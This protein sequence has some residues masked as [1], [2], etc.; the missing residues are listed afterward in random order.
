MISIFGLVIG[1]ITL[2]YAIFLFTNKILGKINIEGWTTLMVVFLLTMSFVMFSLAILGEYLWR[3]L[4]EVKGRPNY[5]ID[6]ID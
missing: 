4:D 2:V 1:L 3:I 6:K 5:I